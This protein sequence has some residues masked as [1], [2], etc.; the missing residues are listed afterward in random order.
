MSAAMF[1]GSPYSTRHDISPNRAPSH[2]KA[3]DEATGTR[4]SMRSASTNQP[5]RSDADQRLMTRTLPL[6]PLQAEATAGLATNSHTTCLEV[7]R[8]CP[9]SSDS[10]LPVAGLGHPGRQHRAGGAEAA[11][12]QRGCGLGGGRLDR[13]H[14]YGSASSG[15]VRN[16]S[17]WLLEQ[18]RRAESALVSVVARAPLS[19]APPGSDAAPRR[20]GP[21]HRHQLL[22]P[23]DGAGWLAF[24]RDRA[25]RQRVYRVRGL[26]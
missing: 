8:S 24:F 23:A 14:V 20:C 18:R 1:S 26:R 3:A 21:S 9:T 7:T 4:R 17:D 19:P 22:H 16:A 6:P 5:S 10:R 13:P 2:L 11:G 15:R 25:K 12:G